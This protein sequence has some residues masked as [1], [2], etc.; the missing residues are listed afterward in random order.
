MHAVLGEYVEHRGDGLLH[1]NEAIKTEKRLFLHYLVYTDT[2]NG[3]LKTL[4]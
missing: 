3:K 4:P 2:K 1:K